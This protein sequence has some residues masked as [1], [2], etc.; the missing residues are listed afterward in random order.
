METMTDETREPMEHSMEEQ[1]T[2]SET[3]E[4]KNTDTGETSES[5]ESMESMLSQYE[6]EEIHKGKVI[7]GTVVDQN[8]DG[9]LVDVGYKCEGFLPTHEWTHRILVEETE[10]PSI[11]DEIQVQ[12]INIKHGEE[13][14]LIVSRW[15]CEFDN[16]WKELEDKSASGDPFSVRGIRKVKG[17][18]MVDCCSLEG[19]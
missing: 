5:M 10:T 9:W 6:V 12:V 16:R 14:Q 2:S 19:F 15:R 11:G 8:Q 18:L 3:T 1:D 17:G 13:S 7:K 4:E